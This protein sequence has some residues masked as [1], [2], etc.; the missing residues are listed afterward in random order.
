MLYISYKRVPREKEDIFLY[1]RDYVVP[2]NEFYLTASENRYEGHW[3]NDKKNGHGKFYYLD[4]GQLYEGVWSDG[5]PK[6]GEMIDFDRDSAPDAT[7][8]PIPSVRIV[9]L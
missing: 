1:D 7:K 6:S 3:K 2:F 8:Y 9:Y 5:I 4:K